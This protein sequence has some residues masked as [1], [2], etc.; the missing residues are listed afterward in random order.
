LTVVF[1]FLLSRKQENEPS[2]EPIEKQQE[3][4]DPR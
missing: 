3:V 2:H 4:L 1:I